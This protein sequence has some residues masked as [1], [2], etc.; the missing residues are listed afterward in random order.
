M[1]LKL[2]DLL[3]EEW[4]NSLWPYSWVPTLKL[5]SKIQVKIKTWIKDQPLSC[6]EIYKSLLWH[7]VESCHACPRA[8]PP[9]VF[10]TRSAQA[11]CLFPPLSLLQLK[12]IP[13][14][15]TWLTSHM[16]RTRSLTENP[17]CH[18]LDPIE[19]SPCSYSIPP[20]EGKIISHII[21]YRTE[22][23][24]NLFDKNVKEQ[25]SLKY[26]NCQ[27]SLLDIYRFFSST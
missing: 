12:K 3:K 8:A 25:L 2:H 20:R 13:G 14:I 26:S 7:S 23:K 21:G 6:L 24:K 17:P 1:H 9:S 4:V 10:T 18:A 11:L 16:V 22:T 27:K 19:M 15:T 5:E